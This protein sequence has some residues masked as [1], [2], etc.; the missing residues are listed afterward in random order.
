MNEPNDVASPRPAHEDPRAAF[1]R[2]MIYGAIITSF[3]IL[4]GFVAVAV[5]L[6]FKE[7]PAKSESAALMIF[8]GLNTLASLAA[9]YWLGSS[10][11]AAQRPAPP[12][13]PTRGP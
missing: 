9:G 11:S 13:T 5:L 10:S 2:V 6:S 12:P 7:I 1:S 4:N 8:G 3:I